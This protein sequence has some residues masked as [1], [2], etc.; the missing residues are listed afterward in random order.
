MDS[1][2][3]QLSIALLIAKSQ[4]ATVGLTVDKVIEAW[5][6]PE[7]F[8]ELTAE[9]KEVMLKNPAGDYSAVSTMLVQN[10]DGTLITDTCST[11]ISDCC[12]TLISNTCST[13]ISDC[14]STRNTIPGSECFQEA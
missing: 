7:V 14:C 8:E 11:L 1:K 12:S 2:L 13:L 10:G 9:Q 4:L 3:A 5:R 6:N